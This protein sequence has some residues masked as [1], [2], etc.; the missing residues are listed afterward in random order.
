MLERSFH[1]KQS[2]G[3]PAGVQS[4]MDIWPS[5]VR[6]YQ[7]N[8]LQVFQSRILGNIVNFPWYVRNKDLHREL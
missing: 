1:Q 8:C 7:R 2:T 6:L 3:L 4:S 5:I